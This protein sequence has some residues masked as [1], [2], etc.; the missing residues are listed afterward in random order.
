VIIKKFRFIGARISDEGLPW[1]VCM[2]KQLTEKGMKRV[3]RYME[4]YLYGNTYRI[5]MEYLGEGWM[6]LFEFI[7]V[8]RGSI[9]E[10]M[11]RTIFKSVLETVLDLMEHGI[12]HHDIKDENIMIHGDN[13]EIVLIDFGSSEY[14]TKLPTKTFQGHTEIAMPRVHWWYLVPMGKAGGM[15]S[16]LPSLFPIVE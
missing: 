14:V 15:E 6:D 11:A 3:P 13:L 5:V 10:D 7:S 9:S 2:L 12:F 8:K 1:E 16:G 4:H